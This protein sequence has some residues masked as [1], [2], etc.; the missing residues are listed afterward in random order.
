MVSLKSDRE[1]AESGQTR[2]DIRRIQSASEIPERKLTVATLTIWGG[3]ARPLTAR[4]ANQVRLL[5]FAERNR[6]WHSF[7]R[8]RATIAAVKGLQRRGSVRLDWKTYQFHC[9]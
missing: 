6:G 4:G 5:S 9:A 8:D 2:K 1:K 7:T 3:K